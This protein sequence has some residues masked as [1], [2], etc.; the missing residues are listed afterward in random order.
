MGAGKAHGRVL[1]SV[2]LLALL[3]APAVGQDRAALRGS[4]VGLVRDTSG[5]PLPLVLVTVALETPRTGLTDSAGAYRLDGIPPGIHRVTFRR[6]GFVQA[7]FSLLV[8]PDES[9]RVTIELVAASVPIDSITVTGRTS[10]PDLQI[11]GFYER[12]RQAREGAG[13]GRFIT[14]EEMDLLRPMPRTTRVVETAGVRLL[15]TEGGLIQWPVGRSNM[16]LDGGQKTFLMG[17][18]QMA[19]FVDGI[20]VDIGTYHDVYRRRWA[21]PGLDAFVHPT[22]IRAIEIYLS[23]SGTPVQFQSVRNAMCGS[24]VIWTKA[25]PN[26]PAERRH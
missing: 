16:I 22:E 14:P 25:G 12:S 6:V 21:G 2:V 20:E 19:V 8:D 7:E 17:P 15:Q 10:Y 3:A 1:T 4:L 13:V 26:R 5:Q 24:I 9:Q 18:C 11:S 23:A